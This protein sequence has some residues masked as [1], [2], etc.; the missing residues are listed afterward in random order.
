M[1]GSIRAT[2]PSPVGGWNTKDALPDM[3]PE[4]A[5]VLDNWYPVTDKVTLRPGYSAWSTGMSGNV[6]SLIPYIPLS[7]TGQL[8]GFNGTSAYNVTASGAVGAAVLTGLPDA[9]WSGLNIGTAGG[10]FLFIW[11]LA[12]GDEPK[13]YNGS[14]WADTTLTGPTVANIAVAGLHQRR[15][16]VFEKNSLT[17]W[18]GGVNAITGAF[19]SFSLAGIAK[20]G[21]YIVGFKSW[22][23]DDYSGQSDLAAF[24]TSEGE[25][26]VYQGTDVT[27]SST[28][29]LVG[30]YGNLGRPIG[31][32]FTVKAGPEII[33]INQDGFI[34]LT[35]LS[36][37]RS[38]SDNVAISNKINQAVTDAA[39]AAGSTFGW[40]G[41]IY[42][43]RNMILFNV[44]QE[45]SGTYHQYVANTITKAWCR[46]TGI[47]AVCWA[48][49]GDTLFF[50]GTDGKT[51][52][53]DTGTSDNGTNISTDALQA[54]SYF[55]DPSRTKIFKLA[56]PLFDAN[57]SPAI[58][59]EMNTDFT[60][61]P[62]ESTPST[63]A[64]SGAVWDTAEWDVDTWGGDSD[65]Y[66]TWIGVAGRG[67][68]GSIRMRTAS[69]AL[70]LGWISTSYV[71]TP[72]GQL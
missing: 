60:V 17:G 15:L 35:S 45:T 30:I 20:K 21:G 22:S 19:S 48:L 64:G 41:I 72:G 25:V 2:L 49:V 40:Q 6:E 44:P 3:P 37:D 52:K 1:A 32:R 39:A 57:T 68:S 42:P 12:G 14:V 11:N 13:T 5:I 51:Y 63:I 43:A 16:W 18:Y 28:W 71:Y 55:K 47:N 26:I 70:S 67:T 7:G 27:S 33:A 29:S 34:P 9:R 53:F 56:K 50:G 31:K 38:Q 69:N 62:P 65:I 8:F 10:Q 23:R 66:Q 24:F 54:F 4:D 59:V 58:A 46:F 61:Y 36:T